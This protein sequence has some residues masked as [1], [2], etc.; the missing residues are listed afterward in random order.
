MSKNSKY[1][2]SSNNKSSKRSNPLELYGGNNRRE[3]SNK[4]GGGWMFIKRRGVDDAIIQRDAQRAKVERSKAAKSSKKSK[5]QAS[6]DDDEDS[7]IVNSS[8]EEEEEESTSNDDDESIDVESIIRSPPRK[9]T[10][11]RL[12]PY[13]AKEEEKK[14]E[15]IIC[16]STDDDDEDNILLNRPVFMRKTSPANTLRR[17]FDQKTSAISKTKARATDILVHLDDSTD[18]DD[19]GIQRAIKRSL[20]V[21]NDD[22]SSEGSSSVH[23]GIRTQDDEQHAL[24]MAKKQSLKEAKFASSWLLESNS[25]TAASTFK[26]LKK[27]KS[28]VKNKTNRKQNITTKKNVAKKETIYKSEP[29]E[30]DSDS[31]NDDV[32]SFHDEEDEHGK[33]ETESLLKTVNEL[34]SRVLHRMQSFCSLLQQ[35]ETETTTVQ[36]MIVDGAL[37]LSTIAASTTTQETTLVSREALAKCLSSDIVIPD[38]QLIGVNW[39]A[40]MDTLECND[41]RTGRKGKKKSNVNGVLA[42]EMGLG[43]TVQTIAFLAWLKYGN[44]RSRKKENLSVRNNNNKNDNDDDESSME[45]DAEESQQPALS[46]QA[47]HPHLIVVPASVL[48]NWMREFDKI[49]PG[50]VVQ[51]YHGTQ[52]E[53][54]EL[55]SALRRRSDG[56][57]DIDVLL[58]TFSYFSNEKNDD[59]RFLSKIKFD[60]MVVDEAHSLKNPKGKRYQELDRIQ[61]SHR[62]LL[63]GTPVQNNPSELLALL[64]FLM[65][66]F[67]SRGE[68]MNNDGGV[69]L[70]EQITKSDRSSKTSSKTNTEEERVYKNLKQLLAPFILR[71]KKDHVVGQALPPKIHKVEMVPFDEATQGLYDSIL[72]SHFAATKDNS[73]VVESYL[74]NASKCK[75]VF[76]LLRKAANHPLLLRTRHTNPEA[77]EELARHLFDVGFFGQNE[78]CTIELVRNELTNFSDFDIHHAALDVIDEFP[79]MRDSLLKYTLSQEDLFCSPKFKRLKVLLPTLLNEGH[80]V[81]IFSQWTRCLD[82][83]GCL[84]ESLELSFLRLDGSTNIGERQKLIDKFNND[85][86]IPVFLLSTRAGG[87]GINLTSAD[88]VICH[89]LDFNPFN[90]L[91]AE[92]RCHRI[93]QTKQV[94]IYKMITERTV[95]AD[96]YAMQKRKAVMTA[97]IFEH[98]N[99]SSG[100]ENI[101]KG[102]KQ[103]S[104]KQ[105]NNDMSSILK[106]TINRFLSSPLS[107]VSSKSE[108][109]NEIIID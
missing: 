54:L 4:Q 70:L 107:R 32:L 38:Y 25:P 53:R 90:D 87:M 66:L 86:R 7:F 5:K 79:F 49:C 50:L 68:E 74:K 83:L 76:T 23:I 82:L 106:V 96:I 75:H 37:A 41:T 14:S 48:S 61:T 91:Q 39:M 2:T 15:E 64:C 84:L 45:D 78:S 27:A 80:R 52:E 29:I 63:T 11:Q 77:A 72:K 21:V 46:N 60:Y 103:P 31:E 8:E 100:K 95:D 44:T 16:L 9:K 26:R 3:E 109:K 73:N 10:I 34:S 19:L 94:T 17:V 105:E 30:L 67:Q 22:D 99:G 92:D 85:E 28:I 56:S 6:S 93:G 59:R 55:R 98:E 35:T 104:T 89:D 97:A 101:A 102:N 69:K 81:L 47:T 51:K 65:P 18:E 12:R 43:K 1:F 42:D 62:L 88:T 13:A 58:T 20:L 40:L 108:G 33:D 57:P 24:N 36:G 71:R